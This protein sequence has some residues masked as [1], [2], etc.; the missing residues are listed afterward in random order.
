MKFG[1]STQK[2]LWP[3]NFLPFSH[4]PLEICFGPL[5]G[6]AYGPL[7]EPLL[8]DKMDISYIRRIVRAPKHENIILDNIAVDREEAHGGWQPIRLF[9]LWFFTSSC[10][11]TVMVLV[12][13]CQTLLEDLWTIWSCCLYVFYE[14]YYHI[15]SYSLG[16][17]FYQCIYGFILVW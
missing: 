12:I 1:W 9:W 10:I 6:R 17:I 14:Y 11:L 2:S 13:R 4:G 5:G 8:Y 7:W 16:S 15:S 3:P